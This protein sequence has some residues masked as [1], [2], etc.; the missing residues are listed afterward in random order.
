MRIAIL[1]PGF[2]PKRAAGTEIA[3]QTMARH[4]TQRG[5]EVHVITQLDKGLPTKSTDEGFCVHR[6]K[7]REMRF[8]GVMLFWIRIFWLLRTIDP[9]VVHVQSTYITMPALLAKRFLGKPCVVWAQ[10]SDIYHPTLLERRLTK[11]AIKN[12]NAIIALTE[13]MR[14]TMQSLHQRDVLVIPNGIDLERFAHLFKA[15]A[16]SELLIEEGKRIIIFVGRLHPVKGVKYLI[17]AMRLITQAAPE[18]RLILLGD[19]EEQ[20]NLEAL[21]KELNLENFVTFQGRVS[22]TETPRF[23]V[24]SDILVLPSLSEGFPVVVLE[25]MAC[26]LP[27]VATDVRGVSEIVADDQNGFTVQPENPEAIA[28]RV[29]QLLRDEKLRSKI[30]ENNRCHVEQYSWE[31]VVRRLEAVYES[32]ARK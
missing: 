10:G 28:D 1:V 17:R 6:L 29:L 19:G 13:H 2:P 21:T 16:R 15:E 3:T 11:S 9:E 26:G 8:L 14:T 5:H 23:M 12:A 7:A 32:V 27:I 22:N 24:A 20:Q 4:L 18:A 30:G 25:A 31:D